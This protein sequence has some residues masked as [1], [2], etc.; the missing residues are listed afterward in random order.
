MTYPGTI[1]PQTYE[2]F[3][4]DLGEIVMKRDEQLTNTK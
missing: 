1:D 2:R 3:N 4:R